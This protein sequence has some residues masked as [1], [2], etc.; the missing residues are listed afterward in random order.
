MTTTGFTV[1]RGTITTAQMLDLKDTNPLA[2]PAPAADEYVVPLWVHLFMDHAGTDYVQNAGTDHLA[3][4][5]TGGVEIDEIGS[6]A[7]CTAFLQASADDNF[8]WPIGGIGW[9]GTIGEGVEWDN[10]GATD[11]ITGNSPVNY[12]IAYAIVRSVST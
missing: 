3:L 5:Y 6:Q 10:N 11:L 8:A 7:Q 4:R 2:I 9:I 1:V 12:T